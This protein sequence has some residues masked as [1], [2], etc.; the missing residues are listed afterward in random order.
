[1]YLANYVVVGIDRMTHSKLI[2]GTVRKD[3]HGTHDFVAASSSL[4]FEGNLAEVEGC[5]RYFG[6]K[7]THGPTNKYKCSLGPAEGI[8]RLKGGASPVFADKD[9]FLQTGRTIL[10]RNTK[11]NIVYN[12]CQTHVRKI[13]N[14]ARLKPGE[15]PTV[16]EMP[17]DTG[18]GYNSPI[19]SHRGSLESGSDRPQPGL[20][21]TNPDVR[22]EDD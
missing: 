2:V 11:Y 14:V 3:K 22:S 19:S 1:M 5:N 12:N 21:V 16:P 9:T 13:E 15:D 18:S 7:C 6:A 8:Y 10:E 17:G 20:R 4:I